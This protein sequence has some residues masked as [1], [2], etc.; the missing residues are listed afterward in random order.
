MRIGMQDSVWYY[1]EINNIVYSSLLV[2]QS[3]L[4]EYYVALEVAQIYSID[5]PDK[6]IFWVNDFNFKKHIDTT[7]HLEVYSLTWQF[8]LRS[9][10][11]YSVP[12][13]VWLW[14]LLLLIWNDLKLLIGL[15]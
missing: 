1:I 12:L 9:W 6:S 10:E 3:Q 2:V 5:L 7:T 8:H 11:V 13:L 4:H 15:M 14:Q